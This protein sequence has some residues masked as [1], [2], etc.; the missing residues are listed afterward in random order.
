MRGGVQ[1]MPPARL[2]LVVLR[3]SWIAWAAVALGMILALWY[4]PLP[5]VPAT[6]EAE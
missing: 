3:F 6:Q 2:M 4:S 5:P 1:V